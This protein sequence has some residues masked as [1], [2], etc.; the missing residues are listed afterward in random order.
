MRSRPGRSVTS[1]RP[2]GRIS[3]PHGLTKPLAHVS[4]RTT[5]LIDPGVGERSANTWLGVPGLVVVS[6]RVESATTCVPFGA[7]LHAAAISSTAAAEAEARTTRESPSL[8]KKSPRVSRMKRNSWAPPTHPSPST[9]PP[10]AYD[11]KP[12]PQYL[13]PIPPSRASSPVVPRVPSNG[14]PYPCPTARNPPP[15]MARP[16]ENTHFSV[17]PPTLPKNADLSQDQRHV[18]HGRCPR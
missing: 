11:L 9:L 3:I 18:P 5:P 16:R 10:T 4:A 6:V 15:H 7:S 12:A 14:S 8:I 2:S 13:I 17:L 1:A